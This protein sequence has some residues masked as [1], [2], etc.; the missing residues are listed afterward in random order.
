VCRAGARWVE[1]EILKK[2]PQAPVQVYAVWFNMLPN[3][4]RGGRPAD[5]LTDARVE[6]FWD[7]HHVLGTAFAPLDNWQ[8][9]VLWDAYFLYA[10][11]TRWKPSA[12]SPPEPVSTGRTIFSTREELK[13]M[14]RKLFTGK[15]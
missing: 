15:L 5:I 4:S 7:E 14:F 9:G 8:W 1:Q 10:P 6:Q 3:D 2:N 11:Q 13:V 12:L